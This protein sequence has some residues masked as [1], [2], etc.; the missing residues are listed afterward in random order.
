MPAIF[1]L[2]PDMS[3]PASAGAL[4]RPV[5]QLIL[6]PGEPRCRDTAAAYFPSALGSSKAERHRKLKTLYWMEV[7]CAA[8]GMSVLRIDAQAGRSWKNDEHKNGNAQDRAT[9]RRG[10]PVYCV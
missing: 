9:I 8:L 4:L 10:K 3:W 6:E 5:Q 2:G 7:E 1:R